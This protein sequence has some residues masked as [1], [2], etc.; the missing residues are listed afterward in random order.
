MCPAAEPGTLL[1][2]AGGHGNWLFPPISSSRRGVAVVKAEWGT[3]RICMSCGARF[4]DMQR[5]PIV[6]PSCGATYDPELAAK[7]RRSR[8][9]VAAAAT[10]AKAAAVAVVVADEEEADVAGDGE[11]DDLEEVDA[12]LEAED[13]AVEEEDE[14]EDA[15]EAEALIEDASELGEDD[16]MSDVIDTA[17]EDDD[18]R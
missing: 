5:D 2:G 13:E 6:C 10:V 11:A 12:D 9:P 8:P 16:E 17:L 15:E 1:T 3:K 4:Y 18:E 14:E 7:P